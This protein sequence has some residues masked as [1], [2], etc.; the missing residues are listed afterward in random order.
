MRSLPWR[1]LLPFWVGDPFN[2]FHAYERWSPSWIDR[3]SLKAFAVYQNVVARTL[4]DTPELDRMGSKR[5]IARGA[6]ASLLRGL[7]DQL[8][9]MFSR[10]GATSVASCAF[11]RKKIRSPG[12]PHFTRLSAH[13]EPPASS[14]GLT[15]FPSPRNSPPPPPENPYEHTAAHTASV[16][17]P[18]QA[19]KSARRIEGGRHERSWKNKSSREARGEAG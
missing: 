16:N 4:R 3:F 15:F 9:K 5:A 2:H 13:P 10:A 6:N 19:A 11:H 14:P 12:E 1:G 8:K 17:D 7:G 18:N